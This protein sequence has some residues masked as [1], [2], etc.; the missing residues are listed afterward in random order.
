LPK[1]K[2]AEVAADVCYDAAASVATA[3][4]V[5]AELDKLSGS[6]TMA[7]YVMRFFGVFE[8]LDGALNDSW[9]DVET[10][11]NCNVMHTLQRSMAWSM[12]P[13][14]ALEHV[15]FAGW[16]APELCKVD[17]NKWS[18]WSCAFWSY[19]VFADIIVCIMQLYELDKKRK[20]IEGK[21]KE[22]EIVAIE[23]KVKNIR[24]LL[25]RECIYILPAIHWSLPNWATDP[26]I[27]KKTLSVMCFSEAAVNM[28][29]KVTC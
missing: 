24:C 5:G 14:H 19:Y 18:A 11:K 13:Y 4:D 27:P 7:R 29:Q 16:V 2:A 12:V 8:S 9:T 26:W 17:A 20:A 22:S 6:L 21:D 3:V 25:L 15:A 28:Y 1:G 10:F 23:K